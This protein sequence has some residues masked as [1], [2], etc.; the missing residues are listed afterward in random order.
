MRRALTPAPVSVLATNLAAVYIGFPLHEH[1]AHRNFF[2][3]AISVSS[4]TP[5]L[6]D[7]IHALRSTPEV[8]W[9][10]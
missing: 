7:L 9:D 1:S 5:S 4:A 2:E 10:E 6:T 8:L 3:T